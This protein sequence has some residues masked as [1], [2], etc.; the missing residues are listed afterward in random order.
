MRNNGTYKVKMTQEDCLKAINNFLAARKIK[1][2]NTRVKAI[3]ELLSPSQGTFLF[4][5]YT[6]KP[7]CKNIKEAIKYLKNN[8][9]H[10]FIKTSYWDGLNYEGLFWKTKAEELLN[11]LKRKSISGDI[12]L[13][14]E[15]AFIATWL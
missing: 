2:K 11:I 10:K 6:K 15:M 7:E 3:H 8:S 1:V 13:Y 14:G 5:K 12:E 4:W 9:P